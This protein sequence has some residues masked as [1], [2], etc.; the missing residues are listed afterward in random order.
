[1]VWGS[2]VSVGIMLCCMDFSRENTHSFPGSLKVC[3]PPQGL[4]AFSGFQFLTDLAASFHGVLSQPF[5]LP[6]GIFVFFV[7]SHQIWALER[8]LFPPQHISPSMLHHRFCRHPR[9]PSDVNTQSGQEILWF[10]LSCT[11][12][13]EEFSL[14]ILRPLAEEELA[15][16]TRT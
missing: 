9:L 12:L 3:M 10:P 7:F 4:W 8:D 11:F 16:Q 5:K 15:I 2:Y 14:N 6:F 13:G 1:M